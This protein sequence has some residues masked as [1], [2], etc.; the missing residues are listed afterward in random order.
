MNTINGSRLL[1]D[2]EIEKKERERKIGIVARIIYTVI[3][4]LSL[5]FDPQINITKKEK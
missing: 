3:L 1:Y 5:L 4:G 2:L